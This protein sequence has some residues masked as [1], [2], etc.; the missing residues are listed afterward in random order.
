MDF[1]VIWLSKPGIV[2]GNGAEIRELNKDSNIV[3]QRAAANDRIVQLEARKL[4]F[5]FA[6]IR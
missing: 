4:R 6:W 5:S 3:A 2:V 1:K